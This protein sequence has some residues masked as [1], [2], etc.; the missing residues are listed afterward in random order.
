MVQKHHLE[1]VDVIAIPID[2]EGAVVELREKKFDVA[3]LVCRAYNIVDRE[4]QCAQGNQNKPR[5]SKRSLTG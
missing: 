5:I 2:I 4:H 3:P 1:A